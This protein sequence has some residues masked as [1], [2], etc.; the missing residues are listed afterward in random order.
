MKVPIE[1][2]NTPQVWRLQG[3]TVELRIYAS[4]E[5][6]TSL[7]QW[8][9]AGRVGNS[10]T[11]YLSILCTVLG[12][13]LT[14]PGFEIDSTV[15]ALVNPHALY[16]AELIDARGRRVMFIANF[17]VNTL[18]AGDPSLTWPEILLYRDMPLVQQSAPSLLRQIAGMISLAA[19]ALT[20][21]SS[22][23]TGVT[24]LSVNPL[25]PVFPIALAANDPLVF[26]LQAGVGLIVAADRA[27]LVNGSVVVAAPAVTPT[28]IITVT[29]MADMAGSLNVPADQIIDGVSF[30]INSTDGG[31]NGEVSWTITAER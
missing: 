15:D 7:G 31:D 30:V 4:T 6:V 16:N 9:P 14:I 13:V 23:N 8:I 5:F 25:D 29:K 10:N 17:A 1:A 11:F 24:A 20:K 19:G 21:S 26:Q 18:E 28:S 3:A 2:F 12:N 27:T 22:T